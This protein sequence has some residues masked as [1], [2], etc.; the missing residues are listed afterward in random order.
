[1]STTMFPN[2][3]T[4]N[5]IPFNTRERS[6]LIRIRTLEHEVG[7][8][9]KWKE[10]YEEERARRLEEQAHNAYPPMVSESVHLPSTT[11]VFDPPTIDVTEEDDEHSRDHEQVFS[12]DVEDGHHQIISD[13]DVVTEEVE[14]HDENL[15]SEDTNEGEDSLH[16]HV[17]E[18]HH[19]LPSATPT[20]RRRKDM[21]LAA[22]IEELS[23]EE[24]MD[25]CDVDMTTIDNNSEENWM[26]IYSELEALYA[27]KRRLPRLDYYH[28]PHLYLWINKQVKES[29]QLDSHAKVE[30]RE[31]GELEERFAQMLTN[32][33]FD[34]RKRRTLISWEEHYKKL[35]K[36]KE[37]TGGFSLSNTKYHKNQ[38]FFY[39]IR[40]QKRELKR[41]VV[42][43]DRLE[44]L[45]EIGFVD[46]VMSK[47]PSATEEEL[48]RS[49]E[50][51]KLTPWEG[52]TVP[53]ENNHTDNDPL[54]MT[55]DL[56]SL[57]PDLV[58]ASMMPQIPA[59]KFTKQELDKTPWR[60]RLICFFTERDRYWIPKLEEYKAKFGHLNPP[61]TNGEHHDLACWVY[62]LRAARKKNKPM[63]E[64]LIHQLDSMGFDWQL[65]ETAQA[66]TKKTKKTKT[67]KTKKE[68]QN[69]SST[70]VMA[71]S[72]PT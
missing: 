47:L 7:S 31:R 39:W 51:V 12:A 13:V 14:E 54:R 17:P 50:E 36:V 45:R 18:V 61:F 26:K 2:L 30:R 55:V 32:L 24:E 44:K 35:T 15:L 1:M 33:G 3:R 59:R 56:D 53:T 22:P 71:A 67:S 28:H 21:T 16:H 23:E 72:G 63:P 65:Q 40:N 62:Y 38:T 60:W 37:E 9:H 4:M 66:T 27:R 10:M 42:P 43:V 46:W 69:T 48:V 19:V 20:R 5:T 64:H 57:A 6:L 29:Q 11:S 25:D 70:T 41:G 49:E 52:L 68:P 34:W 58:E 8:V